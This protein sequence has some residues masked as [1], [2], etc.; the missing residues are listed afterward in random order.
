MQNI[1]AKNIHFVNTRD[2]LTLI[3]ITMECRIHLNVVILNS[4]IH[5]VTQLRDFLQTNLHFYHFMDKFGKKYSEGC[6]TVNNDN[7]PPL[8]K[9]YRSSFCKPIL[10]GTLGVLELLYSCCSSCC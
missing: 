8:R 10:S 2:L 9:Y 7:I 5:G 1:D 4:V 6:I 3:S